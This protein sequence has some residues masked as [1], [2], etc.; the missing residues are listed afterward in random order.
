MHIPKHAPYFILHPSEIIESHRF[1]RLGKHND[2]Y[3][4]EDQFTVSTY[5]TLPEAMIDYNNNIAIDR[6]MEA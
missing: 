4:L 1:M 2:Q 3:I 6:A 5:S